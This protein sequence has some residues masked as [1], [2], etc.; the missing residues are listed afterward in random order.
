M[1]DTLASKYGALVVFGEHRYFGQS[2]PFDRTIAFQP[3]N[4]NYLTV[5]NTMMDYVELIKAI[6]IKY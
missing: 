6:K 4:N 3:G 2:F 1:T 5:E